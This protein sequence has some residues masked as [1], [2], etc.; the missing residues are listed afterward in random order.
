ME[1]YLPIPTVKNKS[2]VN[3]EG[4][5]FDSRAIR[6]FLS[7]EEYHWGGTAWNRDDWN[8]LYRNL[9][10]ATS[11][12]FADNTFYIEGTDADENTVVYT[13]YLSEILDPEYDLFEQDN[14]DYPYYVGPKVITESTG[15][16]NWNELFPDS[17]GE[18]IQ[19]EHQVTVV[20]GY[21]KAYSL[22]VQSTGEVIVKE[23]ATLDLTWGLVMEDGAKMTIEPG[24][25]VIVGVAGIQ[26]TSNSFIVVQT[27]LNNSAILS[28][29]PEAFLFSDPYIRVEYTTA[30]YRTTKTTESGDIQW[31]KWQDFGIPTRKA[32][33]FVAVEPTTWIMRWNVENGEYENVTGATLNEPF[34]GYI[35]TN[36]LSAPGYTYIMTGRMNAAENQKFNFA[37]TG[38]QEEENFNFFANSY[39]TPMDIKT[40]LQGLSDEDDNIER[41]VHVFNSGTDTYE[42][43]NL[44]DLKFNLADFTTIAPMQAFYMSTKNKVAAQATLNYRNSVWGQ[45]STEPMHAPQRVQNDANVFNLYAG[46][47]KAKDKLSFIESSNYTAEYENGYD[48]IKYMNKDFNIFVATER[49]KQSVVATDNIEGTILTFQAGDAVEYQLSF[50][51][52]QCDEYSIMDLMTGCSVDISEGNTYNFVAE[53]KSTEARFQIIPKTPWVATGVDEVSGNTNS[54]GIYTILGQYVGSSAEWDKLSAGVYIVDGIKIVK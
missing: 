50:D 14:V 19:V 27:D 15:N 36:Q 25:A 29:D 34:R 47:G 9:F 4:G 40:F 37:V 10:H 7:G 38:N 18:N 33:N 20:E 45:K 11:G 53:P 31:Y 23:G 43:I 13:P 49:G 32:P 46:T 24:A 28:I 44:S 42:S 12:Y 1:N 39:L 30:A 51:R 48:A 16:G 41:T 17:E 22:N 5:K 26:N 54:K 2:F 52:V 21:T 35:I 3:I 6:F 8:A